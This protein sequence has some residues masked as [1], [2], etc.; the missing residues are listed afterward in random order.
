MRLL[1]TLFLCCLAP[2]FAATA[3]EEAPE[4]FGIGAVLSPGDET[5]GPIILEIV[6]NSPAERAK[7]TP[8]LI[9]SGVAGRKTAGMALEECVKLIRGE[10][11]T[12]V[13]IEV[14]NPADGKITRV[15]VFRERLNVGQVQE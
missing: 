9:I 14:T 2:V 4:L 15:I 1:L 11:G 7:L 12:P 3:A 8:G 6:P 13:L 10:P 5:T